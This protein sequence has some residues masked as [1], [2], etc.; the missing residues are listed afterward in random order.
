MTKVTESTHITYPQGGVEGQGS[1]LLVDSLSD[2][3]NTIIV[4]TNNTPFHPVDYSWP[5]QP[6]DKGTIT[7]L[8]EAFN[9]KDAITIGKNLESG[10]IHPPEDIPVRP[11]KA[12]WAF[13]VGHVIKKPTQFSTS[14]LI[15]QEATL[16]VDESYRNRL[17]AAHTACHLMALALNKSTTH[18]WSG[19]VD[20]D[21]LGNPHLDK[22]AI[23]ESQILP[24]K[25]IDNYRLGKSVK[26]KGFD[27]DRFFSKID[28]IENKINEQISEWIGSGADIH[29]EVPSPYLD[30]FRKW[31]CD[32]PEGKAVIPCGGTHLTSL[33]ELSEVTVSIQVSQEEPEITVHTIP[34]TSIIK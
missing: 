7:V 34:K 29:M 28:R 10:K 30:S 22:L 23:E 25:S 27:S 15:G 6:A 4:A 3:D 18:L 17:N 26:T 31:K 8:G 33:D 12:G 13:I 20:L 16:A 2:N 19:D 21:S 24:E 32:L 9:V 14:E 11:G 1:I 5:D